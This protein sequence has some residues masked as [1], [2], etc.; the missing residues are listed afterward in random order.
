MNVT[1]A[2]HS[3]NVAAVAQSTVVKSSSVQSADIAISTAE[4]D[5]VTVSSG[6]RLD[7]TFSSYEQLARTTNSAML[8]QADALSLTAGRQFSISVEG[9]LNHREIQDI[10]RALHYIDKAAKELLSGDVDGAQQKL[11][12]LDKQKTLS[13]IGADLQTQNSLSVEQQSVS[14]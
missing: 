10:R 5:T 9:N 3:N 7:A 12:N 4:G 2:C 13:S 11:Q 14:T 6:T 8:T 1:P